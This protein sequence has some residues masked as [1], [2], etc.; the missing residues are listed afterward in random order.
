MNRRALGTYGVALGAALMLG[1]RAFS[2]SDPAQVPPLDTRPLRQAPFGAEEAPAKPYRFAKTFDVH[3]FQRGNLH[4]HTSRSDGD[5]SPHA[6]YS[7][8]RDHGYDFVIVTDHNTFTD[9]DEFRSVERPGFIVIGG[10]EITMRGAG[11]EVHVNALCTHGPVPGG[12]FGTAALALVHGVAEARRVGGVAL[13]NHPNFTWGLQS[14]DISAAGGAN[15]IEI[16]SGHP[17]VHTEGNDSHLS[18]EGLWDASLT[19]GLDFMGVAVDDAHHFKAGRAGP[20]RAWVE[21]FAEHLD[22]ASICGAL[23]NGMLYASTGASLRRITITEDAYTIWPQDTAA[24]V[25][26]VGGSGRELSHAALEPGETSIS[27]RLT[28][29]EGYVRARVRT[30]AGKLAWTPAVRVTDMRGQAIANVAPPAPRP[31]G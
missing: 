19:A 2:A 30:P 10:E 14:S 6:V 4:T 18:H 25:T 3:T 13:I 12:K 9:P 28:G 24:E 1:S 7:W 27:Y 26:F 11:R 8:Y 5:S 31:P 15:L 29:S 20:G 22:E 23:D 21:V 17:S 16:E